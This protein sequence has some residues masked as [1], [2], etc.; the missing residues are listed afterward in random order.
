[1]YIQTYGLEQANR[2]V[3]K[4]RKKRLK[5]A[6]EWLTPELARKQLHGMCEVIITLYKKKKNV[7]MIVL[8]LDE[9]SD[10]KLVA[11][12]LYSNL[13]LDRLKEKFDVNDYQSLYNKRLLASFVVKGNRITTNKLV[14]PTAKI[15]PILN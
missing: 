14:A 11:S 1:M 15:T 6:D 2:D 10:G 4:E 13:L 7:C 3:A 12:Y 9:S 8:K 5:R